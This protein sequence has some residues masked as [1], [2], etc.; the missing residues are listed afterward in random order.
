[1]EANYQIVLGCI[2]VAVCAIGAV[3]GGIMIKKGYADKN[4]NNSESSPIQLTSGANS[5]NIHALNAKEVRVNYGI[6]ERVFNDWIKELKDDRGKDKVL[7]YLLEDLEKK[8]VTISVM[9]S[10]LQ[11]GLQMRK[12]LEKRLAE[13]SATQTKMDPLTKLTH[14]EFIN[15]FVVFR[16]YYR[17]RKTLQLLNPEMLIELLN[18]YFRSVLL[19]PSKEMNQYYI[20]DSDGR[21]LLLQIQ[22]HDGAG[23]QVSISLPALSG[24]LLRDV[25]TDFI[26]SAN[27]ENYESLLSLFDRALSTPELDKVQKSNILD[28]QAFIKKNN[29]FQSQLEGK[30]VENKLSTG[31][32]MRETITSGSS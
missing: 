3:F 12:E 24:S 30:E 7:E 23:N 28:A 15:N 17:Y 11:D 22:G 20:T 5:P 31:K 32:Q 1:M 26:K 21:A 9:Q 18:V 4:S 29:L 2:I 19:Y 16:A 14:Q 25:C 27:P 8:D 13:R 10:Q 6:P